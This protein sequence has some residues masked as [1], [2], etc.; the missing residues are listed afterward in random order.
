MRSDKTQPNKD[1]LV[2]IS[3]NEDSTIPNLTL[4]ALE[5][6]SASKK[7]YIFVIRKN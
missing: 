4:K 7:N 6:I 2:F 5:I 1:S 3:I